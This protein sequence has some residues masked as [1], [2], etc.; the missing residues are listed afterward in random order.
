MFFALHMPV[1]GRDSRVISVVASAHFFSHLYL[2]LLPPIFPL[3]K[4]DLGV[5]YASLGLAVAIPNLATGMLQSP[6][7]F[8][9]DRFGA[10][11][12][13]IAGQLLMASSIALIG[14]FPDYYALL[15]LMLLAGI[16]NA[17]YHPAD[18]SILAECVASRRTGRAFSIHTFG[19]LAGFAV[20]PVLVVSIT[21]WADWPVAMMVLGGLG[22]IHAILMIR[23]RHLLETPR[24]REAAA[25][26]R[27][28]PGFEL[29]FN[30]PIL[31]ALFFFLMIATVQS[32]FASFSVVVLDTV[33][34]L[35]LTEANLAL[36]IFLWLSA[37]GVLLGGWIAD[38]T[39]RHHWVAVV[40][41]LIVA[42]AAMTIASTSPGGAWLGL[43]FA[44][45]GLAF[46]AVSPSRDMLV[47]AITPAGSSGKVFGF[48]TTGFNIGGLLAPPMF[49]ALIDRGHADLVFWV[50]AALAMLTITSIWGASVSR[51]RGRLGH[52]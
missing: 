36:S 41:F 34:G 28:R 13:L 10:A 45:A 2:L 26:A 39:G 17:V 3:L 38:V 33:K 30:R 40:C 11:R 50:V 15:A 4:I 49:G 46:G 29:L 12:I 8:L 44:L 18:Y 20:A 19:G 42:A 27:N 32:G 6:I 48:V 52:Y 9:V 25:P 43:I 14:V 1:F 24:S 21:N 35:S 23:Y 22:I 16:G 37:F 5:S 51:K 7:G 47:R 31:M